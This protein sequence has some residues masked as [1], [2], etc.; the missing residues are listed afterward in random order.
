ME[1][2]NIGLLG[3]GTVGSAVAELLQS[4]AD[5]ISRR[6]GKKIQI[7]AVLVKSAQKQRQSPLPAKVFTTDPNTILNDPDIP[8]I[9]EVMG[10]FEPA[11]QYL[12]QAMQQ[13]KHIITAN[14]A[15]LAEHGDPLIAYAKQQ[16]M[17]LAFEAA[18]AGGIPII[19]ILK[20]GLVANRI[21]K[22]NAIV[23]GTSN[24]ILSNMYAEGLEFKEALAK[25]QAL[26][27]AEQD[28]T[29]DI[30]GIDA[31]HKITLLAT[32]AFGIPLSFDKV[33]ISGIR[34]IAQIDIQYAR[35]LGYIIKPIANTA[36]HDG[37]YQLNIYPALL[38]KDYPLARID[39]VMNALF[40]NAD[41]V[42][43]TMYYGPG[44][45]GKA[46][47]SSVIADIVDVARNMMLQPS[48]RVPHLAYQDLMAQADFATPT[49]MFSANYLRLMVEDKVGVLA[50]IT[51]VL[52]Q[53][54][55]SIEAILQ[56]E[57]LDGQ[58]SIPIVIITKQ[59]SDENLIAALVALQKL[60]CVM[61][62]AVRL[63]LIH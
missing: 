31:A 10:G 39:G 43:E 3:Y 27:Y 46:T 26:G 45:G 19:K 42:N 54:N 5:E 29:F 55:I 20:E 8:I 2:V 6:A 40:V 7:K 49:Q 9:V 48:L 25:A 11:N 62:D 1:T 50:K 14:K 63:R 59:V 36:Y 21:E 57:P 4:N 38:P 34:N 60:N 56:K 28:P 22:I 61:G 32:I 17:M 51:E 16:G 33:H 18:V 58:H 52:A 15:L 41:G 24:Y 47:A 23:N 13:G 30:D 44:A 12:M 37:K 35:E 53:F